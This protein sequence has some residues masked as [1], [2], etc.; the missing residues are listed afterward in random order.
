MTL[1]ECVL[2]WNFKIKFGSCLQVAFLMVPWWRPGTG[3]RSLGLLNL[4]RWS[5]LTRHH[6]W[7][8]G[9]HFWLGVFCLIG[10]LRKREWWTITPALLPPS[11]PQA[12]KRVDHWLRGAR[13]S[14]LRIKSVPY[15]LN[16]PSGASTAAPYLVARR[17]LRYSKKKKNI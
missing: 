4:C 12:F 15:N 2:W 5:S 14:G 3:F 8:V 7:G 11:P 10:P 1:K 6:F 13:T 16:A 9:Q 17:L